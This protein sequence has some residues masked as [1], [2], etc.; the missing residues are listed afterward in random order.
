MAGRTVLRARARSSRPTA[1]YC[2]MMV[3]QAAP[4]TPS[5]SCPMAN[6]SPTRLSAVVR[7]TCSGGGRQGRCRTGTPS[8]CVAHCAHGSEA[9]HAER[10]HAVP[11]SQQP[12]LGDLHAERCWKPQAAYRQV[13]DRAREDCGV[14]A[15]GDQQA[16]AKQLDAQ[17]ERRPA[18]GRHSQR[19]GQ[20]VGRAAAA[21]VLPPLCHDR[22]RADCQAAKRIVAERQ[23][24]VC[25]G[26][27]RHGEPPR[28][29]AERDRV[30]HGLQGVGER[31]QQH[32]QRKA[33]DAP[34]ALL[35]GLCR[36]VVLRWRRERS[37]DEPPPAS[38]A[39]LRVAAVQASPP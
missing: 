9:H 11:L 38:P 16:L 6:T 31:H 18:H 27:R 22:N 26:E 15:R 17:A 37:R 21:W 39:R 24:Q 23:H 13:A 12:G 10:G 19:R 3:V 35:D 33:H 7:T 14:A 28:Q 2:A 25:G 30:H 8:A 32:G 5:P 4:A 34:E 36:A 20:R 1:V 29:L